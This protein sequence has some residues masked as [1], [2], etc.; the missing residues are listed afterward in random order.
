MR[1]ARVLRT[2]SECH[3][4]TIVNADVVADVNP[5]VAAVSTKLTPVPT[6]TLSPT[7]VAT[8]A[9]ALTVAVPARVPVPV[10]SVSAIAAVEPVTV[11]PNSSC[12]VTIGCCGKIVPVAVLAEGCVVKA[13]FVAAPAVNATV[14]GLLAWV[15]A[16]ASKLAVN[17]AV[18]DAVPDTVAV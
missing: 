2:S 1:I 16:A 13:S 18:P 4:D 8:P 12:T 17:V 5:A 10:V 11:F 9:T 6:L 7:N 3:G 14:T 15:S